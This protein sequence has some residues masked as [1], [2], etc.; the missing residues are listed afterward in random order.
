MGRS[1]SH[2]PAA[3]QE[4]AKS[5]QPGKTLEVLQQENTLMTTEAV[6]LCIAFVAGHPEKLRLDVEARD[7][8]QKILQK[9]SR[10]SIVVHLVPA[11]RPQDVLDAVTEHHPQVVHFSGH[12]GRT[13][14]GLY[15]ESAAGGAQFVSTRAIEMLFAT[16]ARETRLVVLN[17]CYS[18]AQ[19]RAIAAHVECVIGMEDAIGDTDAIEFAVALYAAIADHCSV[20]RAFDAGKVVLA[21]GGGNDNIVRLFCRPGVDPAKVQLLPNPQ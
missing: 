6:S 3:G 16:V 17:A 9:K 7:I 13:P 19:A 14:P 18:E 4:P 20:Q 2:T 21:M 15:F 12:G 5:K 1:K 10:E 11:A 8:R